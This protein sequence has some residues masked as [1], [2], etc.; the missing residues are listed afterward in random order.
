MAGMERRELKRDDVLAFELGRTSRDVRI[1]GVVGD[2]PI[3]SI[4]LEAPADLGKGVWL[5]LN[6]VEIVSGQITRW[7]TRCRVEGSLSLRLV[8]VLKMVKMSEEQL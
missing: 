2:A 6:Q 7:R 1:N 4:N 5:E 3:E 8:E